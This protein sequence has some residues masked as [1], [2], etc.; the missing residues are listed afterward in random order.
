[1]L[2]KLFSMRRVWAGLAVHLVVEAVNGSEQAMSV[3]PSARTI[4]ISPSWGA[5]IINSQDR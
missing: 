1:M 5:F 2:G 3:F 4:D